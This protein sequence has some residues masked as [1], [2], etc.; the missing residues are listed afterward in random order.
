M[1]KYPEKN[2]KYRIQGFLLLTGPLVK[3]LSEQSFK[4]SLSKILGHKTS[5][6]FRAYLPMLLKISKLVIS[7]SKVPFLF[8]TVFV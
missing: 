6:K 3:I 5:L 1:Q 4:L 8:L 7:N 2:G